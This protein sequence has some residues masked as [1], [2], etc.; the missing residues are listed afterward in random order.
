MSKTT[1]VARTAPP[2]DPFARLGDDD[3][4]V[5]AQ[6]ATAIGRTGGPDAIRTLVDLAERLPAGA[7]RRARFAA[8]VLA[9]RFDLAGFDVPASVAPAVPAGPGARR[10]STAAPTASEV[11]TARSMLAAAV[12]AI[13]AAEPTMAIDCAGRRHLVVVA[14]EAAS[15]IRQPKRFLERR[16]NVGQL[17]LLIP[18]S[19]QYAPG[20]TILTRPDGD[21]VHV[22]LYRVDGT[23]VY[24]GAGTVA[25][26]LL[27]ATLAATRRPGAVAVSVEV[28]VADGNLELTVDSETTPRLARRRP[29]AATPAR[30]GVG[31]GD[32][33]K[34]PDRSG[35]LR[36]PGSWTKFDE[37]PDE[38]AQSADQAAVVA[39]SDADASCRQAS[40]T[41]E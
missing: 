7:A 22:G 33:P 32:A 29:R 20:L 41:L 40:T 30:Q 25:D 36:L 27:R 17:A 18:S 34:V 10:A 12:P 26:G 21:T 28:A 2:S 16:W 14:G 24:E 15:A 37:D 19:G 1:T 3:P 39:A 5:A 8:A 23:A 4:G 11:A 35:T 9:H 6:A 38:G 13:R 31:G